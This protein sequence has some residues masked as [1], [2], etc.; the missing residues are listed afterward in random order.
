MKNLNVSK[1]LVQLLKHFG[2][3]QSSMDYNAKAIRL[4]LLFFV[5]LVL[6]KYMELRLHSKK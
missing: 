1:I 5:L 4:K 3:F 2:K 6:I